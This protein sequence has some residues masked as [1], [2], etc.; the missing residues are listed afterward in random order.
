MK[1]E[2]LEQLY[3]NH[4]L[5]DIYDRYITNENIKP[6]LKSITTGFDIKTIGVSVENREINM[7]TAGTGTTKILM[8]SQMHGN[9]STTTKAVLDLLNYLKEDIGIGQE[10]LK[11]CTLSIIPI[12]N[13]D[14][15]K[16]YTRVNANNIDLNRDAIALSQPESKLLNKIFNQI[17]PDFCFNLHDQRTIFNVGNTNKPAT[18][19]FLTPSS[20]SE[21]TITP[22][23]AISMQLIAA[24]NSSLQEIVPGQIGRYDDSFNINCVGDRFQSLNIPTVLFEAGHFPNDYKR[25]KTRALICYALLKAL[26]TIST[27]SI[28]IYSVSDYLE[29]PENSKQFYDVI[30]ENPLILCEKFKD[31]DKIGILFKETLINNKI[32]YVPILEKVGELST[33]F[34]HQLYNCKKEADLKALKENSELLNCIKNYS[35][36]E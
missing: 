10:I 16:A 33:F 14:G 6:I 23:R 3:N 24:M 13:P 15:A 20:D 11:T 25:D 19:S 2:V 27:K 35:F 18:V 1:S 12:L 26:V 34:G 17:K 7:I 32:E 29:I 28:E 22:S 8:W 9:E 36:L 31:S 5:E 4:K 21:R 30:V